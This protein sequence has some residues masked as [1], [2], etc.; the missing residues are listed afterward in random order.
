MRVYI[1]GPYTKGDVVLNVRKAV[2][3]GQKVLEK[4]HWPYIPH[5]THFWHMLYPGE[6]QQW[7]D[8]DMEYLRVCHAL[9]RIPGDSS[10]ADLEV[11]EANRLGIP[12]YGP[13]EFLR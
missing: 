6:Y 8:L 7:L 10:G 13:E 12:V 9:V 11:A 4:G 2:E 5:L 1:A 3:T